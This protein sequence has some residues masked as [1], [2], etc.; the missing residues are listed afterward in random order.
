MME[1]ES[2]YS[3]WSL[4]SVEKGR[5][6]TSK[7]GLPERLKRAIGG[8]DGLSGWTEAWGRGQSRGSEERRLEVDG[9]VV[10]Q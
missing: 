10:G 4:I 7:S 6:Q 9:W 8:G 3:T 5:L 2:K 1:R